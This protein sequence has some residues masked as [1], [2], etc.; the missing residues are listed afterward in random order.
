M[1]R[2]TSNAKFGHIRIEKIFV[3]IMLNIAYLVTIFSFGLK[4]TVALSRHMAA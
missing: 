1:E 2:S 3:I 4:L